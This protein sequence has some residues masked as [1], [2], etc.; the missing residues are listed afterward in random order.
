MGSMSNLS[1]HQFRFTDQ[2]E[3]TSAHSI[4]AH[5]ETGNEIGRL[6]FM[7]PAPEGEYQ[8]RPVGLILSAR[9]SLDHQRQG[10]AT[11][12]LRRARE[13]EPAVHHDEHHMSDMARAWAQSAP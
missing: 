10:V 11:E 8:R 6:E 3:G 9:V 2:P 1:P 4:R 7:R 13:I 5:D 12:M